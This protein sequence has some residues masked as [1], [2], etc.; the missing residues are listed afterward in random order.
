MASGVS[1]DRE[2]ALPLAFPGDGGSNVSVTISSRASSASTKPPPR[3]PRS[4]QA[5]CEGVETIGAEAT[6]EASSHA[7][8]HP[9]DR[10][11]MAVTA[12]CRGSRNAAT[13]RGA[14]FDFVPTTTARAATT[15]TKSL[16]DCLCKCRCRS[17]C[18]T[19]LARH[20]K[21]VAL[22]YLGSTHPTVHP[23]RI[24][25]RVSSVRDRHDNPGQPVQRA[26][27]PFCRAG[28]LRG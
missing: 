4:T 5:P 6:R 20:L 16:W 1:G 17:N 18:N 7:I 23:L 8:A 22:S 9:T 13:A 28:R 27:L 11:D 10:R 12:L 19:G 24:S 21:R 14:V 25:L 15:N 3:T 2:L 26:E